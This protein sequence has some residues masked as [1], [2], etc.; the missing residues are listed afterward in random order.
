VT[1]PPELPLKQREV[2]RK[3][4][5]PRF[6]PLAYTE[7]RACPHAADMGLVALLGWKGQWKEDLLRHR[8]CQ[9]VS[10]VIAWKEPQA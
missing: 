7:I 3:E 10:A 4:G 1:I 2:A 9:P 5:V 6:E 8:W